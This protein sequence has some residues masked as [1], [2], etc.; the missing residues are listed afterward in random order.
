MTTGLRD[1]MPDYKSTGSDKSTTIVV[2]PLAVP[3]CCTN[4][5]AGDAFDNPV[6]KRKMGSP[7][8]HAQ[9]GLV[10]S[11]ASITCPLNPLAIAA[12]AR[13]ITRPKLALGLALSAFL[14]WLVTGPN[15]G[16]FSVATMLTSTAALGANADGIPSFRLA[17]GRLNT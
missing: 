11:P 17:A 4:P 8:V 3:I 14:P 13:P 9:A 2:A 1:A 10:I 7:I 5:V 6:P 15:A 16:R 12:V